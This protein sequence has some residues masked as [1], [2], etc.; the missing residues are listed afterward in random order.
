MFK[1][2]LPLF[3]A[4][5]M[6]FSF[7]TRSFA[8][9]T[10]IQWEDIPY[11]LNF[12]GDVIVI[13]DDDGVI[14]E[15]RPS[16]AT[17]YALTEILSLS[18]SGGALGAGF[19][20]IIAPALCIVVLLVGIG[21]VAE[22]PPAL[23]TAAMDIWNVLSD[24]SKQYFADIYG[25]GDPSFTLTS[26]VI[27]D[28]NKAMGTVFYD[29][30]G[31]F[32]DVGLTFDPTN[33]LE[34]DYDSQAVFG[35]ALTSNIYTYDLTSLPVK[36]GNTSFSVSLVDSPFDL[37]LT[38]K[39]L[40]IV[41]V[42]SGIEVIFGKDLPI[43]EENHSKFFISLPV[44]R[45]EA[46]GS[47]ELRHRL[48]FW[49][50]S[51]CLSIAS[52]GTCAA[53]SMRYQSSFWGESVSGADSTFFQFSNTGN[54]ELDGYRFNSQI[55][56][57]ASEW[58]LN[59]QDAQNLVVTSPTSGLVLSGARPFSQ[60]L[61]PSP[62]LT[63]DDRLYMPPASALTN[64]NLFTKSNVRTG[65]FENELTADDVPNSKSESD[66]NTDSNT[67][68]W[69]TLWDWLKKIWDAICSI[70]GLIVDGIKDV[71][72]W[73]FV[74][75]L[76]E[77]S[78][79]VDVYSAKFGWV[80]DVYYFI[81]DLVDRLFWNVPPKIPIHLGDAESKYNWG[82]STYV[83]DMSWYERYKN[84]GDTIISGIVWLFFLWRIFRRLPDILAGVGM[85]EEY[86]SLDKGFIWSDRA[87]RA[88]SKERSEIRWV[89][90]RERRNRK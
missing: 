3:M 28:F 6:F 20:T 1:R 26:E 8:L 78:A 21:Y 41:N 76:T 77:L 50:L 34:Y 51:E 85:I 63:P 4:C 9:E 62:A 12:P 31:A 29:D 80:S 56:M 18:A 38:S 35:D 57:G 88:I 67:G 5:V 11:S 66:T 55:Y 2:I 58:V 54:P 61:N 52:G 33:M 13:T 73:L 45:T 87:D 27:A 25:S 81:S 7:V 48:G 10:D 39:A 22:N 16:D 47:G 24:A 14:R 44:V 37:S 90:S 69:S 23:C 53:H 36:L 30:D 65:L 79:L 43:L 75:D 19:G 83:L 49:I 60:V 74:P 71:L 59:R 70:P 72:V 32:R 17:P 40:K 46:L 15:I 64:A 82:P 42:D 84:S 86:S 68:F 89:E